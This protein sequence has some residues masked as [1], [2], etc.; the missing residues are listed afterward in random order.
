MAGP[1]QVRVQ[2]AAGHIFNYSHEDAA[3]FMK[4]NPGSQIVQ[5]QPA[6]AVTAAEDAATKSLASNGTVIEAVRAQVG[7]LAE[8]VAGLVARID[9]IE[10]PAKGKAAKD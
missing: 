6:Q 5:R 9:A 2:D 1:N 3:A 10:A 4:A 8:M 7:E